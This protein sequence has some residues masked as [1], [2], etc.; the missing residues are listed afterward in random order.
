MSLAKLSH[1]WIFEADRETSR[2]RQEEAESRQSRAVDRL[3]FLLSQLKKCPASPLANRRE[4]SP[5]RTVGSYSAFGEPS[6]V[7][8]LSWEEGRVDGF[9]LAMLDQRE[10]D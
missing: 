3:N 5:N 1:S 4:Q 8:R 9:V 7:W 2:A 10:Q 6:K